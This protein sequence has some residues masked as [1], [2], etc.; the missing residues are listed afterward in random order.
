[1]SVASTHVKALD[2][3]ADHLARRIANEG[4]GRLTWDISE[5]DALTWAIGR[6]RQ[7][8]GLCR[9]CNNDSRAKMA[10]EHICDTCMKERKIGI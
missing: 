3:R 6:L 9:F 10:G 5:L 1:M 8:H 4:N 7:L 2:R